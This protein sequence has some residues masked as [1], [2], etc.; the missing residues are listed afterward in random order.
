[1][2]RNDVA[3]TYYTKYSKY[4]G[5]WIVVGGNLPWPTIITNF[6]KIIVGCK[7]PLSRLGFRVLL[8][9]AR[10]LHM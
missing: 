10:C 7:T 4:Y 8:S 9:G 5:W 6:T 3:S 2:G 1:M